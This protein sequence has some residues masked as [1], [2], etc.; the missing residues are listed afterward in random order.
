MKSENEIPIDNEESF[1][2]QDYDAI[3]IG[4]GLGGLNC[5]CELALSGK[6]VLV[7]EKNGFIGGRCAGY[8]KKGFTV[9]YGIHAFALGKN[10][11]LNLPIVQTQNLFKENLLEWNTVNPTLRYKDRYL[12]SYLP[13]D[14]LHF[15]NYFRTIL[16]FLRVQA[17][18]KEKKEFMDLTFLIKK[19]KKDDIEK[20]HDLS[21]KD[22]INRYSESAFVHTMMEIS[23]DSYA[24]V[25][26]DYVAAKDFIQLYQNVLNSSGTGYPNGGC[27]SI[28]NAY[29]KIIEKLNGKVITNQP[30]QSIIVENNQV[31][32]VKL[33]KSN[34]ELKSN[35]VV[36][37][38]NWKYFLGKMVDESYFSEKFIEKVKNMK[39]SLTSLVFHV[40][41][42][43]P[44]IKEKF[45]MRASSLKYDELLK[46]RLNGE[47]VKDIGCFMPI[48]SNIDK[49][50][51]P[52]GKQLALAGFG[53]TSELYESNKE[54]FYELGLDYLQEL[55]GNNNLRDHIEW[56][57]LITP[58]DLENLFGEMGA[59]IGSAQM[60]GQVRENRLDSETPIKGLY[61]CGDDSGVGLF[62]VG[63]ELAALSGQNCA[64]L[65]IQKNNE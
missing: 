47:F 35:L 61:H 64:K 1:I 56:V 28:P 16:N 19:M 37:N 39:H 9:D 7:L 63:T 48:V 2:E 21:V 59:I 27:A 49:N 55:A 52:E 3:I 29:K 15:W 46:R 26:Y 51:A 62:G 60:I 25:P 24:V 43:K 13:M 42:D 57:D 5:A 18:M 54:A 20:L 53:L 34:K 44:I 10:G 45:V 65:I 32:G 12:K 36:S 31:I 33:Q 40:A 41:L 30:V 14:P 17:P 6:K 11:P 38:V 22:F 23:S 58:K 4:A 50:L 8:K